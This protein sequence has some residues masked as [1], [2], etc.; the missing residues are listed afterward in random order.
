MEYIDRLKLLEQKVDVLAQEMNQVLDEMGKAM[1]LLMNTNSKALQAL[2]FQ[3]DE[4]RNRQ[5]PAEKIR[6]DTGVE[7]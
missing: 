6:P 7:L 5:V 4:L 2:Q 3:I 1:N